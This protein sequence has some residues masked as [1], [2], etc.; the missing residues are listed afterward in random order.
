[1][2]EGGER[3]PGAVPLVTLSRAC[4]FLL[5]CLYASIAGL[6]FCRPYGNLRPGG[7]GHEPCARS[8]C[9]L[10]YWP[11]SS[12]PLAAGAHTPQSDP[13]HTHT[14]TPP[15][16]TSASKE[17]SIDVAPASHRRS[18]CPL[19][20]STPSASR[21]PPS[22]DPSRI[23]LR[24][25]QGSAAASPAEHRRPHAP[26][27]RG[28][29]RPPHSRGRPHHCDCSPVRRALAR[30]GRTE[31]PEGAARGQ[32]KNRSGVGRLR[33]G[34]RRRDTRGE[35]QN[36]NS[37][38]TSERM[39]LTSVFSSGMALSSRSGGC[40]I[41]QVGTSGPPVVLAWPFPL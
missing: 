21:W 34:P 28:P 37:R 39:G 10:M 7:P 31:E 25:Q 17:V 40:S 24:A 9:A 2:G 14:P 4:C 30:Q 29:R 13:F 8:M 36:T 16:S 38:N 33:C 3:G 11:Y 12:V 15:R 5:V 18:K 20:A 19:P 27:F 6:E 35:R 1:M 41:L 23:G 26:R 32:A 22:Q